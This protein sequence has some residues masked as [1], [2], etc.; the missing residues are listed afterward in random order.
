MELKEYNNIV[1]KISQNLNNQA[2]ITELLTTLQDDYTET[3]NNIT[4]LTTQT[5][6]A[7]EEI[8]QLQKTNMNLFLRVSSP[9]PDDKLGNKDPLKYEDL[10]KTMEGN[11]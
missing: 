8:S 7:Q 6:K 9:T 2:L 5:Q 10:I 1:N 4:N 11:Q 3:Q